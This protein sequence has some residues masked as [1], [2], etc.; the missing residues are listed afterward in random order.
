MG[1]TEI[2]K[3]EG[4]E[5]IFLDDNHLSGT[6]SD[7]VSNFQQAETIILRSNRFSGSIPS[8]FGNLTNLGAL[9]LYYNNF[10]G[11]MPEEICS[12]LNYNLDQLKAD[13]L[14]MFGEIA[15]ECECCTDCCDR[16]QQQCYKS[17]N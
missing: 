17:V 4:L 15:V 9:W 12:L 13:C 5:K 16:M 11:S 14:D 2:G 10:E 3:M 8:T 7:K 1:P 6:I